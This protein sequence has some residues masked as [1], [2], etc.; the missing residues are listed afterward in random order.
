MTLFDQSTR[1]VIHRRVGLLSAESV[2]EWGT[3]QASR[4]VCHVADQLRVALGDIES[5]LDQ[6]GFDSAAR[7]R[8]RMPGFSASG[9]SDRY[10]FTGRRGRRHASRPSRNVY[11]NAGRVAGRR[12]G[13]SRIDRPGGDARAGRRVGG[14]SVVR[15]ADGQGVGDA[16]LEASRRSPAAIRRIGSGRLRPAARVRGE[17]PRHADT[18]EAPRVA[19]GKSHGSCDRPPRAGEQ[20]E[21]PGHR[22]TCRQVRCG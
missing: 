6:S 5:P 2:G 19:P 12:G 11:D 16:V 1:A 17:T 14:A 8:G 15:S 20:D 9:R 4:M 10:W 13:A 7:R 22:I 21:A 3:M 18:G